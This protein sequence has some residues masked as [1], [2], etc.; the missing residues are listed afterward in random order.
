MA[1][2]LIVSRLLQFA[3][4]IVVFGCGAFRLYGLDCRYHS[5]VRRCSDRLRCLV[6]ARN[7][8]RCDR[9]S[10]IGPEPAARGH[11]EHGGLGRGGARSQYDQHGAVRHQLRAR[12][13]LA[14]AVRIS[15]DRRLP[16]A[17]GASANAGDPR[18]L[19][20]VAGQ[21]R[22]GR[23]CRGGPRDDQARPSDKSNGAF[24]RCGAVAR[25]LGSSKL[26]ARTGAVPSGAAWISVVR[27]VVPRFSHMGYAAVVLLAAT[28]AI[29]TL[30]LVGSVE[31]LAG[32]AL[33]PT[34]ESEDP[35]VFGDGRSCADQ[36]F[37]PGA[38]ASPRTAVI[39]SDRRTR[40]LGALRAGAW[41]C[42]YR[43]GQRPRHLAAGHA[44]P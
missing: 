40:S 12:L 29:N 3:A 16:R 26:A 21:P 5:G 28:G 27:D 17:T 19:A 2:V 33:R 34:A 1:E 35:V 4:V 20:A 18:P 31:A 30:L 24:A 23:A 44:P 43:R 41:C 37:P 6:L 14:A 9:R 42:R 36:P 11:R 13:V 25:R 32:H 15:P 22:L 39:G 8:S 7:D 10:A 38:A